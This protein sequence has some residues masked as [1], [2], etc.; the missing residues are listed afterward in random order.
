MS[1]GNLFE[2][3]EK[4]KERTHPLH[5]ANSQRMGTPEHFTH[6]FFDDSD[7]VRHPPGSSPESA[8]GCPASC[9]RLRACGDARAT[10]GDRVRLVWAP[11]FLE[12]ASQAKDR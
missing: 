10:A 9:A 1:C 6:S 2:R 11:R 12:S 4:S 7:R 5:K 3:K 8:A